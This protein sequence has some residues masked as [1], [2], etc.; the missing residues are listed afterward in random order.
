L[1][2]KYVVTRSGDLSIK[3]V[4]LVQGLRC[5]ESILYT[6]LYAGLSQSLASTITL[7][8]W[9]YNGIIAKQFTIYIAAIIYAR[10][11]KW[12]VTHTRCI[13]SYGSAFLICP[14]SK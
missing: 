9:E 1:C 14:E 2:Q 7:P 10:Y 8:D 6:P 13:Y 3:M 11:N 12:S 4:S 5:A